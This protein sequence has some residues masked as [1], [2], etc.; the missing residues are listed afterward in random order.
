MTIQV[1]TPVDCKASSEGSA[2]VILKLVFLL[3]IALLVAS[4]AGY[5]QGCSGENSIL[6][7]KV[8]P[9]SPEVAGLGKFGDYQVNMFTGIPDI[10]IPLY[11]IKSKSLS[12]PITLR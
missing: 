10:S 7:P 1:Y 5:G 8:S 9:V 12:L 11:E 6:F 4:T 3:L 2:S